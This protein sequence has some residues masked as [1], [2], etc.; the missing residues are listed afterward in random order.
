MML[1]SSAGYLI[2]GL[3]HLTQ[4]VFF[5]THITKGCVT[6]APCH[7]FIKIYHEAK[8]KLWKLKYFT[9]KKYNLQKNPLNETKILQGIITL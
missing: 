5:T 7:L 3:Q 1:L 4:R 9:M 2:N 8:E 6:L